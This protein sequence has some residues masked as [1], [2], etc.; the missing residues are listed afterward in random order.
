MQLGSRSVLE[1]VMQR[2]RLSDAFDEVVVA[3]SDRAEDDAVVRCAA[4]F[5]AM[6]VRGSESDVLARYGKAAEVSGADG[7]ARITADCPLID[8]DV[9]AVM[10]HRFR[11]GAHEGAPPDLVTNAR[12]RTFPRGLDAEFFTRPSL[13]IMLRE[14]REPHHREHV[15]PYLYEHPERFRIVDYTDKTDHS[16]LRWTLDTPEDYAFLSRLFAATND[17]DFLRLPD[18]LALVRANPQWLQLN[19]HV[20][21]KATR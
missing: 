4:A 12:V 13:D 5:G 8:P 11:G 3:T 19:A 15:T 1:H 14:A 21:Q 10:A 6:A 20:I 7:V 17:A 16:S 18:L 2:A 9:L